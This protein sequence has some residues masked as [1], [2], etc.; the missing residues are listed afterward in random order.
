[1]QK[2]KSGLIRNQRNSNKIHSH[3]VS[4]SI[5]K[6]ET[7]HIKASLSTSEHETSNLQPNLSTG[8]HLTSNL[9]TSKNKNTEDGNSNSNGSMVPS[10][11]TISCPELVS[12]GTQTIWRLEPELAY[13]Y[14][15]N[16]D[17]KIIDNMMRL[18]NYSNMKLKF[19]FVTL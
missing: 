2:K 17:Y 10:L 1:M 14:I 19:N 16:T 18:V 7:S 13:F 8:K 9:Q 15:K 5:R 11:Q 12:S 3:Q 6:H 4:L